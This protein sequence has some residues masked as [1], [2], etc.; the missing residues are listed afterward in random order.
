MELVPAKYKR[1]IF[2]CVNDREEGDACAKRDSEKIVDALR[3]HVNSKGLFHKY[4]I[5]KS[6]CLGHCAHG[7][8]I[9]VYPEGFIFRKVTLEDTQ[10]IINEFLD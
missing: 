9:A 3:N 8:T 1:H 7:P 10:K 5:S 6:K 4:N 2:V